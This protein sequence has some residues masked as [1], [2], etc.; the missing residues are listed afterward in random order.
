MSRRRLFQYQCVAHAGMGLGQRGQLICED[1]ILR[2][3]GAVNKA[4]IRIRPLGQLV[5][6]HGP[7][8]GDA[9]A[10]AQQ[11][12]SLAGQRRQVE[13]TE[14][15]VGA[16][17]VPQLQ[18]LVQVMRDQAHVLDGD[19]PARILRAGGEGVGAAQGLA[20]NLGMQGHAL[21]GQHGGQRA[22]GG[23]KLPAGHVV[24]LRTTA[25]AA[26]GKRGGGHR[27]APLVL[28]RSS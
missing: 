7:H 20:T 11:Q 4:D 10:C 26:Q 17:L 22:L 24:G 21:T 18:G 16:D 2:G 1:H 13:V 28:K 15:A 12:R 27:K 9:G 3:S 6:Q 14:G 8:G 23:D 25:D 19:L 5:P